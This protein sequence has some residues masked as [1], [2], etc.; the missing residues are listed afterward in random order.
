MR[1]LFMSTALAL[2]PGLSSAEDIALLLGT[3]R[4]EQLDRLPRGAAVARSAEGIMAL[5][6]RVTALPNGRADTTAAALATFMAQL[7]EAERVIV[8]LSGRFA[9]DGSR[10]WLLTAESATPTILTL[11]DNAVSV[12]SVLAVLSRFPGRALLLIG[13]DED[14]TEVLDPWLAEGIGQLEVPQ[15]VTVLTGEPVDIAAFMDS[16]LAEPLG[17]LYALVADNGT[18]T[19]AGFLLPGFVFMPDE[20]AA[21]P[22]V[23]L[24]PVADTAAEDA[25]WQGAV[26]LDTVA[27]YRNYL[28]RFPLGRYAERAEESI[29]A[30][31]SEPNRDARLAEEA[32]NLS[33]AQR[34][35]VQQSLAILAFDPRGIDGIF[36]DGTRRAIANWQQVNGYPQTTYLT[37]EQINRLDAQGSRRA[38][39]IEAEAER[40][41]AEALRLDRVYWDETGARG[42]VAGLRAYLNRYPAGQFAE[43]AA[44]R[45]ALIDQQARLSDDAAF[46]V[47]REIGTIEA[48]RRYLRDYPNGASQRDAEQM[49]ERLSAPAPQPEVE[50]DRTAREQARAE[51]NA[52]GLNALTARMVES[53]LEQMGL[54]VGTVDGDFDRATR[55]AISRYQE[56]RNMPVTGFLTQS[57]LVLLLA[58]TM[59]TIDP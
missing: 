4:Y 15:G 30:I 31:V 49:I 59:T 56:A 53:R 46:D 47:A 22:V 27:A 41:R 1:H 17:D 12:D 21:A 45:L 9:T 13:H 43:A 7:P 2:I 8:A 5:G 44:D 55:R 10:T 32:L 28:S 23:I 38:A 16:E 25:L 33:R 34:R 24:P 18:L 39:E 50:V 36:G 42:D 6:F 29:S 58:D 51:E 35:S 37:L 48:F 20:L 26:A 57:T 11:G 19:P 3:E 52:L 40:Q 54:N 14:A